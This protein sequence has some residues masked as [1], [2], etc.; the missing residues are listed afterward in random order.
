MGG[1]AA[2]FFL[3]VLM[4]AVVQTGRDVRSKAWVLSTWGLLT[5]LIVAWA[6]ILLLSGPQH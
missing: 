2:F 6:I 3:P 1:L 5:I 4:Y